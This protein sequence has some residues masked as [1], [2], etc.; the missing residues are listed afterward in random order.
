[1]GKS[2]RVFFLVAFILI[3]GSIVVTYYR[4]FIARDYV[5]QEEVGCDPYTEACFIF[6]C[7][8]LVD[9]ECTGDSSEDTSYYKLMDRVAKNAPLC[10]VGDETCDTSV[11]SP[12]ETECYFTLCDP[13]TIRASESCNDPMV[14]A[15]EHSEAEDNSDT[16]IDKTSDETVIDDDTLMDDAGNDS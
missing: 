13:E 4:F 7:D 8:P 2:S 5:V 16:K 15:R 10:E 14:Y 9:E 12:G 11:C 3:T 6:V 1:M